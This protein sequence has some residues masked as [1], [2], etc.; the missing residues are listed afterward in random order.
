MRVRPFMRSFPKAFHVFLTWPLAVSVGAEES[1]SSAKVEP[2]R[3]ALA[4]PP[5]AAIGELTRAVLRG[6]GLTNATSVRFV[7]KDGS[8]EARIQTREAAP[9]VEGF[10]VAR[11]GTQ[12]IEIEYQ[13]PAN[14]TAGTNGTFVVAGPGGES[15]PFPILVAPRGGLVAEKEPNNSI[16]G[17]PVTSTGVYIRGSLD[18][19]GDVDVFEIEAE[20]GDTLSAEVYAERL[21]TTLDASLT[22]YDLKANLLAFNDDAEGRDPSIQFKVAAVGRFFVAVSSVNEK[23]ASTHAYV[24]CV[25]RMH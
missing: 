3:V 14:F 19:A 15:R 9:G 16:R 12:R 20:P 17:A 22:F 25:R 10:D 6:D 8:T 24:L 23:P 13:L 7:T 18:V 11:V 21:G 1:R 2:P 5:A 4:L